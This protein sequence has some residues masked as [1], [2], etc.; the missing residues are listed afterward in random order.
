MVPLRTHLNAWLSHGALFFSH[1]FFSSFPEPPGYPSVTETQNSHSVVI[2]VSVSNHGF[3]PNAPQCVAFTRSS[4]FFTYIF[5]F[6]IHFFL[7]RMG[8]V[9]SG[10]LLSGPLLSYP[11]R[12]GPFRSYPFLPE[13]GTHVP[14][15]PYPSHFRT[16]KPSPTRT[17]P[18]KPSLPKT[19]RHLSPLV[20][21]CSRKEG[22]QRG[23]S[24]IHTC[25]VTAIVKTM[26]A[27]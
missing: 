4:I 3:P 19:P 8:R 23:L 2:S 17:T 13:A 20:P 14:L 11:V 26:R 6:F 15:K 27:P 9:L 10:P 25:L 16:L 5:F 18:L 1:T 22:M 12:S 24:A 7:L 21:I